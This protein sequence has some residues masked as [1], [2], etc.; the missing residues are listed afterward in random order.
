MI[1]FPPFSFEVKV[2]GKY[3]ADSVPRRII[4]VPATVLRLGEEIL[5]ETA[6]AIA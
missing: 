5:D 2:C 6:H 3:I 4:H 1:D